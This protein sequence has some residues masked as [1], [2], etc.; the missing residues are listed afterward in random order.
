MWV[1]C[2]E[3]KKKLVLFVLMRASFLVIPPLKCPL[4]TMES[5]RN[6]MESM[7]CGYKQPH[8]MS[9]LYLG[10]HGSKFHDPKP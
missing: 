4:H 1:K 5:M 3:T 10:L 6:R 8:T 7:H 2:P 9:A